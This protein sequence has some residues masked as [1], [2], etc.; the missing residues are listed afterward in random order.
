MIY[1][2]AASQLCSFLANGLQ[3]LNKGVFEPM[4]TNPRSSTSRS[5]G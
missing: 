2:E 3:K 4:L 5:N 1:L